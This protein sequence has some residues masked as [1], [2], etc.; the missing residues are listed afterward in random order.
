M[1][2]KAYVKEEYPLSELTGRIIAAAREVH[3]VLGPGFM[4]V[5]YQRS[6]AKELPCYDL[7]FTREVNIDVTYKGLHVGKKRVD[8]MIGDKTGDVMV[9]IKAKANLEDVDFIQTLSYLKASGYKVVLLINFG[10]GRLQ[11]K[12][13]AN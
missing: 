11:I 5:I 8:F 10:A 6:L 9:E 2:N 4:E 7:E 1:I 13:L 3:K 12:R